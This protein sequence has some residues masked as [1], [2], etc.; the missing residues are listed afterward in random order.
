V[1]GATFLHG[2]ISKDAR[3]FDREVAFW[4]DPEPPSTKACVA[5]GAIVQDSCR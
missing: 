3:P 1:F 4:G 5:F 2:E